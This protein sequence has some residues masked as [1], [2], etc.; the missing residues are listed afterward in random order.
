MAES[1]ADWQTWKVDKDTKTYHRTCVL[2]GR[3]DRD[4]AADH[5]YVLQSV[6]RRNQEQR[7]AVLNSSVEANAS[8]LDVV[9]K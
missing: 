5:K 9:L 3:I 7:L 2:E 8:K 4:A 1:K 6:A